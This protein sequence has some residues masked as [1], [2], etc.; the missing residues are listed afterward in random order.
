MIVGVTITIFVFA[1]FVILGLST[2]CAEIDS[3][4]AECIPKWAYFLDSSPNE[5][6]DTLAGF[7][8][9]LAVVWLIVSVAQQS[10]ELKLQRVELRNMVAAQ[11]DQVKVLEGHAEVLYDQQKRINENRA[12]G[13]LVQANIS[14]LE[15]A[16]EFYD[17]YTWTYH[18]SKG[19][20]FSISLKTTVSV[21]YGKNSRDD[22]IS[23][24][25]DINRDFLRVLSEVVKKA[26]QGMLL[27]KPVLRSDLRDF[28]NVQ[29]SM[30]EYIEDLSI[31]SKMRV[32]RTLRN[33]LVAKGLQ[34]IH[35]KRLWSGP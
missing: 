14:V 17:H 10:I 4:D 29:S 33:E 27:S 15:S 34:A 6:G 35:D 26:D 16:E 19:E 13:Q 1:I 31:G 22:N 7:F 5:I 28:V 30:S 21:K 32:N 8:S 23:C 2:T 12:F 9:A 20:T 11:A 25:R 24:L 18:D 3:G